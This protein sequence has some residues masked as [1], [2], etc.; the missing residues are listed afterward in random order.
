MPARFRQF[1]PGLPGR[2]G[3]SQRPADPE[4]ERE[5]RTN[6]GNCR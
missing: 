1:S 5:W 3:N 6:D 4:R 2:A